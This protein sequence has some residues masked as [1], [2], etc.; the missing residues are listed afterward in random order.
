V[1]TGAINRA[2]LQLN[3]HHQQTNTRFFTDRMPYLS[4]NQQCQSSTEEKNITFHGLAP[5]SPGV[6]QLC[7]WPLIA[8]GYLGGGL[9]CLSSALWCQYPRWPNFYAAFC[10]SAAE[11]TTTITTTTVS[12][13]LTS[14]FIPEI[15]PGRDPRRS[16]NNLYGLLVQ[17]IRSGQMPFLSN[18]V[19]SERMHFCCRSACNYC[20]GR[21]VVIIF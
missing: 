6:F 18:S 15:T 2:K 7:L 13:C 16:R 9:S 21:T 20:F 8:P 19:S 1:T 10:V 4:P 3:H 17:K 12:F 14:L 11:T 5:R